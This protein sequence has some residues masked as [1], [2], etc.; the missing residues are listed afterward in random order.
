MRHSLRC[1]GVFHW[2]LSIIPVHFRPRHRRR[3]RDMAAPEN[4]VLGIMM[5]EVLGPSFLLPITCAY[6]LKHDGKSQEKVSLSGTYF[7]SV[8]FPYLQYHKMIRGTRLSQS[9]CLYERMYRTHRRHTLVG[10]VLVDGRQRDPN[11]ITMRID[12]PDFRNLPPVTSASR[13]LQCRWAP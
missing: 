6:P 11:V 9:W 10:G 12:T 1:P 4:L 5:M 8:R 13:L 7:K 2:C 3:K